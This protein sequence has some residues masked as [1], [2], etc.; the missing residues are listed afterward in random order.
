MYPHFLL[1]AA[2][3]PTGG[4]FGVG[5]CAGI[6]LPGR[7]GCPRRTT[8]DRERYRYF[9]GPWWGLASEGTRYR[10][11]TVCHHH[12]QHWC[13]SQEQIR[14]KFLPGW[15]SGGPPSFLLNLRKEDEWGH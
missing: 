9:V 6:R 15:R 11:P 8:C 3:F 7:G 13:H 12:R 10:S 4:P 1:P 14:Q 5:G 2:V